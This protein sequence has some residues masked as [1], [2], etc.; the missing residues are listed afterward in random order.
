MPASSCQEMAAE[1]FPLILPARVRS[2]W[3][4]PWWMVTAARFPL[5]VKGSSRAGGIRGGAV[6]RRPR[7]RTGFRVRATLGA[8]TASGTT[9]GDG[10]LAASGGGAGRLA[11][12]GV[13][14][15]GRLACPVLVP[16]VVVERR[17]V[18]GADSVP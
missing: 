9:A 5:M 3:V 16:D 12:G 14:A 7:G 11:D 15:A 10:R 2:M 8:D 17:P 1:W 18:P 6:D 4:P 13:L